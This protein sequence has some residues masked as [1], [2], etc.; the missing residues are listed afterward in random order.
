APARFAMSGSADGSR[1]YVASYVPSGARLS[2]IDTARRRVISSVPVGGLPFG[3]A[4]DGVRGLAYVTS[5]SEDTITA[6]DTARATVRATLA[7]GRSPAGIAFD[8]TAGRLFVA[9]ATEASEVT[10]P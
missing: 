3:V 10:Q 9:N 5:F 2:V 6:I 1:L 8:P 7:A 4:L